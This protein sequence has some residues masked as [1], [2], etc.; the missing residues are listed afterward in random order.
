MLASVTSVALL[1]L[2]ALPSQNFLRYPHLLLQA[3]LKSRSLHKRLT[4]HQQVHLSPITN[5]QA[6]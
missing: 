5:P 1:E 2:V 3:L 4:R 6:K